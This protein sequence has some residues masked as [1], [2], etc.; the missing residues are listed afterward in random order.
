MER[1]MMGAGYRIEPSYRKELEARVVHSSIPE[2]SLFA[3]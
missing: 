2:Q 3:L 1:E